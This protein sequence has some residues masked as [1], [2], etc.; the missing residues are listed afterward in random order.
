MKYPARGEESWSPAMRWRSFL[1]GAVGLLVLGC[2]S[3]ARPR[4]GLPAD[5]DR[6][7]PAPPEDRATLRDRE[8]VDVSTYARPW[9]GRNTDGDSSRDDRRR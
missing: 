1:T 2:A 3:A 7:D 5:H 6:L 9:G 4:A 8:E